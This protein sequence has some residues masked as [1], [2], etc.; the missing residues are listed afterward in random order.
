MEL[1]VARAAWERRLPILAICRGLQTLN[2]ARGGT[3]VQHIPDLPGTLDHRQS[4]TGDRPSHPIRVEPGSETADA[5]GATELNVNSFHH[6]AIRD[7][8]AGLVASAWAPDGVVEAIEGP[9]LPFCIGVQ[10][11]AESN[12]A[13]DCDGRLFKAFTAAAVGLHV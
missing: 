11:H 4:E 5:L 9:E 3:L 12:S 2:V 1:D 7:L 6:Q 8:G 10:W 13:A